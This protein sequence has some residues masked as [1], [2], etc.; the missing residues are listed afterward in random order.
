MTGVLIRGNFRVAVWITILG[1]A[2]VLVTMDTGDP[3]VD[4]FRGRSA[5]G[6]ATLCMF[7]LMSWFWWYRRDEGQGMAA[8][9]ALGLLGGIVAQLLVPQVTG[10][11][12]N[13]GVLVVFSYLSVSHALY[14][15]WGWRLRPRSALEL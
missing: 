12:M 8:V 5:L 1:A 6:L 4:V 3:D 15:A 2:L 13:P 7:Q 14:A 11:R 10:E 9:I